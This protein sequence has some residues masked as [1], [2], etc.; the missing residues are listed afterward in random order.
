MFA[1][2]LQISEN[3][4]SVQNLSMFLGLA[5]LQKHLTGGCCHMFVWD[6]FVL[7]V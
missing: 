5:V 7:C 6:G 4:S 2:P 1:G 3:V